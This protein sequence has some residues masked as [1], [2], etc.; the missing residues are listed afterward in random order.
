M[1]IIVVVDVCVR[2]CNDCTECVCER[3]RARERER[4]T[5][6]EAIQRVFSVVTAA[7]WRR[8]ITRGCCLCAT[9]IVCSQWAVVV[10]PS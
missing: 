10:F 2:V 7:C 1:I 6:E 5:E 9:V 3:D 4:E 8:L